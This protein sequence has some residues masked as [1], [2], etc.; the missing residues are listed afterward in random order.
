MKN[1]REWHIRD[2]RLLGWSVH[3]HGPKNTYIT[4]LYSS[5]FEA[6]RQT[7]FSLGPAQGSVSWGAAKHGDS[8]IFGLGCRIEPTARAAKLFSAPDIKDSPFPYT[9]PGATYCGFA[10]CWDAKTPLILS[11]MVAPSLFLHLHNKVALPYYCLVHLQS[12]QGNSA[13]RIPFIVRLGRGFSWQNF[14]AAFLLGCG[15]AWCIVQQYSF[16]LFRLVCNS[17]LSYAKILLC[18]TYTQSYVVQIPLSIQI[19]IFRTCI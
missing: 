3:S 4:I 9:K 10:R 17:S 19:S 16:L 8:E 11:A 14:W 6:G 15:D 2:I 18:Y 12:R 7:A 5:P 13:P 1:V